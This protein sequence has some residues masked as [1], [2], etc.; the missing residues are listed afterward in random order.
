MYKQIDVEYDGYDLQKSVN[1]IDMTCK[2]SL[3]NK[4]CYQISSS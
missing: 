2:T 3:F 1:M 4:D